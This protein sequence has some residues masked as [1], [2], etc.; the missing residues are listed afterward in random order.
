[1]IEISCDFVEHPRKV[2]SL[3]PE[4]TTQSPQESLKPYVV[5]GRLE[6]IFGAFVEFLPCGELRAELRRLIR[7]LCFFPYSVI[8]IQVNIIY[9][10]IDTRCS[11]D[12]FIWR[13][14]TA[15]RQQFIK[16]C[17]HLSCDE[18]FNAR[19]LRQQISFKE[20]RKRE[21]EVSLV[22]T[23]TVCFCRFLRA[24][25][26]SYIVSG[27]KVNQSHVLNFAGPKPSCEDYLRLIKIYA[28]CFE[29][30]RTYATSY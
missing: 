13:R 23:N 3:P 1:M 25:A 2:R 26:A 10:V 9:S 24:L 27:Q 11:E 28:R 7:V 12:G 17:C 29:V 8:T 30:T 15:C 14:T 20:E 4:L 18:D 22:D 5:R 19:N 6:L 16:C 21:R